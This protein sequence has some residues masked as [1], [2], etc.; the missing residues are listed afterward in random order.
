MEWKYLIEEIS[1]KGP[2][3]QEEIENKL[4]E[5][6]DGGWEAVTIW[7]MPGPN[8]DGMLYILFKQPKSK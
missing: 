7:P 2:D 5:C 6:G 1:F 4:I 8:P 3:D